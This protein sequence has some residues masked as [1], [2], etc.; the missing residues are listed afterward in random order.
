MSKKC[1]TTLLI[2]VSAIVIGLMY[3]L[4]QF[5]YR[6]GVFQVYFS[7]HGENTIHLS[8][9]EPYKEPGY[10][11]RY[12]F[13]NYRDEVVV[14]SNVN[15]N[16]VGTYTIT[17]H[18]PSLN[19]SKSRT[20]KVVDNTKPSITLNGQ[21]YINTFVNNEYIDEGASASDNYDGDITSL[22]Q[23]KSNVNTKKTGVYKVEYKV[24]DK[25]GNKSEVTR[26]VRVNK[27][28]MNTILKYN[29]D[30]YD[31]EPMQ[32][33]FKKS[34]NHKRGDGAL[35]NKEINQY[36]SYYI[37]EDEKVLYLTFDEGG[38]DTT[39]IKEVADVLNKHKIKGTFFLTRNYIINESDFIKDLVANGHLIG[40]HTRNHLNMSTI[41]NESSIKE[42]CEEVTSVEKAYMQVTGQEMK[43][44]FRFP[45]GEASERTMKML[46]DLGYR[47]FFWSHAYYDYGPEL[48]FKEAY[49]SMINYYHNG[50]IYLMHPNNKG[51]YVA[52][53]TFIKEMLDQGYTFKTVD[54]IK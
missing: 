32:W 24:E 50:A 16:K 2:I 46:Q 51:N 9:Q 13:S 53:E 11:V 33:W 5:V 7:L 45:K 1:K 36:D 28:P 12:H 44:T 49:N 30:E 43:K 6:Y 38:S 20:V 3:L 52:L 31:N 39:Y 17:Y 54:Q 37:G 26:K 10:E 41:A 8:L 19:E 40:N 48:S 4:F 34:E 27:N 42:F 18:I 25:G 47:N 23:V 35:P 21:G 14:H 29:Y 15:E 22:M